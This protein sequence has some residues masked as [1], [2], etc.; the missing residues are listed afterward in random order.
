MR[1]CKVNA[2]IRD[3]Q[4][5]LI[6]YMLVVGPKEAEQNAVSVRDRIESADIGMMPLDDAIA[7]FR[8]EVT[9]KEIRQS[10]KSSFTGL[11]ESETADNEY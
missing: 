4:L 3:A 9:N 8:D 11:E 10:M 6:P 7:K 1:S 2:K 5:E